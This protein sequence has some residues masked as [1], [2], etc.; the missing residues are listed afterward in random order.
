MCMRYY[1]RPQPNSA[2][3]CHGTVRLSTIVFIWAML[4]LNCIIKK[5]TRRSICQ[6]L[7]CEQPHLQSLPRT[8]EAQLRV[9]SSACTHCDCSSL[10]YFDLNYCEVP[11]KCW[12]PPATS[13]VFRACPQQNNKMLHHLSKQTRNCCSFVFFVVSHSHLST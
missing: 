2:S 7:H 6:L 5:S 1:Q 11:A 8:E 4:P 10:S 9:A 3:H 12:Q 13:L